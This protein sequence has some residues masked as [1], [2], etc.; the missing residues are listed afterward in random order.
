MTSIHFWAKPGCQ[1]NARQI[2]ALRSAGHTVIVHDLLSE[3]WTAQRLLDFFIDLPIE[4]WFNPNAPQ[5]KSGEISPGM[6]NIGSALKALMADPI[7]IRRPLIEIGDI[8][9]AGF[10]AA[11]LAP[12]LAL[13]ATLPAM[14]CSSTQAEPCLP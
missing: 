4:R 1:T 6:F 5:I 7:L 9:L 12:E 13:P 8:R 10:E 11:R 14:A 3:A 2:E